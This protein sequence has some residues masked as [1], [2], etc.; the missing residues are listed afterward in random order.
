MSNSIEPLDVRSWPDT[1][2]TPYAHS[3]RSPPD[4]GA[5]TTDPAGP[6]PHHQRVPRPQL[7]QH[8]IQLR[9]PVQ[10]RRRMLSP[11]LPTAGNRQLV[12]LQVRVCSVV[13][14]RP[15]P[16]PAGAPC[17]NRAVNPDTPALWCVGSGHQLRDTAVSRSTLTS[18]PH[19]IE[20][21][22]E[23]GP[24]HTR[25]GPAFVPL[26]LGAQHDRVKGHP[27]ESH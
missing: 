21:P 4:S 14:L 13:G 2:G 19:Q 11:P 22:R 18:R 24:A 25:A 1:T 12:N 27:G 9:P 6:P 5:A 23:P 16:S 17:P 10:R 15:P 26:P 8:P 7:L 20:Q 3:A